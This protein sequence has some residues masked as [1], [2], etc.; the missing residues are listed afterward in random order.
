L[1][2]RKDIQKHN[3]NEGA[4]QNQIAGLN[5]AAGATK[6]ER[7]RIAKQKSDLEAQL[8]KSQEESQKLEA[9][10]KQSTDLLATVKSVQSRLDDAVQGRAAEAKQRQDAESKAAKLQAQVADSGPCESA[11]RW[12]V[13]R[14]SGTM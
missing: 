8:K 11:F 5:A 10:A 4:L 7:E 6:E 12:D 14:D 3:Q 2:G 9:Q 13:N 1:R